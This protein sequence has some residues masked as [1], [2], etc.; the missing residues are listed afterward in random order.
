MQT[1]FFSRRTQQLQSWTESALLNFLY[2]SCFGKFFLSLIRTRLFSDFMGWMFQARWSRI[3]LP[4]LI[5]KY[6]IDTTSYAIPREW[7][8]SVQDFFIRHSKT[9]YRT[10]P[11]E[12]TLLCSPAD[13][14]LEVTQNISQAWPCMVKWT[15]TDLKK[16]FGPDVTDFS[17]GDLLFFRLRFSD[18]HRFH[19]FDD[20]EILSSQARDGLLYSVDNTVL[21]TGLWLENKSHLMRL[22]TENFGEILW[23]EVGATNVGSIT[24]HL[25]VGERFHRGQEKWYFWLGGSAVLILFQKNTISLADDITTMS[26]QWIETEVMTGENIW[27]AL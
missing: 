13:G 23:L 24:N 10:F 7:F 18:Y 6:H 16:L 4:F 8:A 11:P 9:E 12:N 26:K 21:K 19:F 17:G 3:L 15:S 5:K 25:W 2:F 27:T 14:C 20:G 1:Q 22:R